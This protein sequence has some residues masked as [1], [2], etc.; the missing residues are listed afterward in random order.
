MSHKD[1]LIRATPESH[2]TD[3]AI[4]LTVLDEIERAGIEMHSLLVWHDGALITEAYWAPYGPERLHMMH[5]VTKSFTSMAVGL[6]IEDGKLNLTDR[7]IDFFPEFENSAAN[8][9]EAMQI[10]HLLTM[11]SGHACGISGGSWRKLKTSWVE[12]FLKQPIVY[13]PGEIF[14]YDSACSYMLSAIV[15]RALG[16]TVHDYLTDRVFT[17]LQMSP[18]IAWD[19]S[20]EGVNSGGNGLTCRTSDLLKLGILH[21]QHGTWNGDQIL[22]ENWAKAATGMQLRDVSLGVLT[23]E[24]YL[25]PDESVGDA[26][27]ERREGYGYQWWRGA[28]DSYAATGLFG[29]ACI[30]LPNER[31]VIAFTAGMDDDDRRFHGLIHDVLRPALGTWDKPDLPGRINMLELS[32]PPRKSWSHAPQNW[33]GTY[34][35]E[36]NDQGITAL[37]LEQSG[38]DIVFILEDHRGVHRIQAGLGHR[39]E[40]ITTMTGARLHHA[41]E[42]DAGFAVAAWAAWSEMDDEG[43]HSLTFDWAFIETAFRDTVRCKLRNGI[44]RMSRQVNV[45]S[46][47]LSLPEIKGHLTQNARQKETAS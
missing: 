22:P 44:V 5:S 21:L 43:W 3:P 4:I 31:A 37:R 28:H 13:A 12:D 41:Y 30:V 39:I 46:S 29:Q 11:T 47:I 26:A 2:K 15:Q 32:P 35:A 34:T 14:I 27:P 10:R 25:G 18:D 7:V 19:K 8:G 17:P 40:S 6:A 24:H 9:I 16:R 1:G 20:P 38:R 45:N 42:P 36:P 33:A 23:G